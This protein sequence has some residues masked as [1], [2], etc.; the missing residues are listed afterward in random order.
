MKSM[1]DMNL[2]VLA[3]VGLLLAPEA[4]A[5]MPP[6]VSHTVPAQGEDLLGETVVFHGFSLEYAE[7]TDVTVLD[8]TTSKPVEH[9]TEL[10]CHWEGHDP[11]GHVGGTQQQ[12]ELMVT[13]KGLELEHRYKAV[14]MDT[15]LEFGWAGPAPSGPAPAVPQ[16]DSIPEAGTPAGDEATD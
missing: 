16:P 11:P 2:R 3:L 5:L 10:N 15:E 8:L 1:T 13:L 7:S 9:S 6:H 14:Y 12:C 4:F